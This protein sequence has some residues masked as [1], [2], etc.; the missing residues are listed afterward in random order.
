MNGLLSLLTGG[1]APVLSLI[2]QTAVGAVYPRVVTEGISLL[3]TFEAGHPLVQE[4]L[5][6]VKDILNSDKGNVIASVGGDVTKLE[7]GLLAL[8]Q[9][10]IGRLSAHDPSVAGTQPAATA[11]GAPVS[12]LA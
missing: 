11:A 3:S 2:V 8:I 6:L 1:G 9:G 10:E 12:P 4:A 7:T 5:T